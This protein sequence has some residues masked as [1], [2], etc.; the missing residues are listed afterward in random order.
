ML[1]RCVGKGYR[2][3]AGFDQPRPLSLPEN[4]RTHRHSA[5]DYTA[6]DMTIYAPESGTVYYVAMIRGDNKRGLN[7]VSQTGWP[8][9]F[10]GNYF[11]D[12]Y[13]GIV[14]LVSS[15]GKRTH[16]MTH[17]YRNQLFTQRDVTPEVDE[18]SVDERFPVCIEHTF[19]K[20]RWAQGGSPICRIGNAGFSTGAHVHHEVHP[21]AKV[22]PYR[23]RIDWEEFISGKI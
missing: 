21:G 19:N 13:G 5:Y 23:D 16:L 12:V 18:S 9:F 10:V 11:Y 15:D 17:S 2:I 4:Q 7:N 14:I 3:T 6:P 1:S 8:F 20:P 22:A